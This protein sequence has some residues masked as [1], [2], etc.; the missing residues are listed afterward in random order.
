MRTLNHGLTALSLLITVSAC[1]RQVG[2]DYQ[3]ESLLR[4]E[5]SVTIPQEF[6]TTELVP[7][8]AFVARGHQ[9]IIDVGVTGQFPAN[10]TL[11]VFELPPAETIR[12]SYPGGPALAEGYVAAAPPDH[13]DAISRAVG[14]V[15]NPTSPDVL[16]LEL[17]TCLFTGACDANCVYSPEA[18]ACNPLCY[19]G[20]TWPPSDPAICHLQV[21]ECHYSDPN[22]D[23]CAFVSASGNPSVEIAGFSKNVRI[24][25]LP[26]AVPADSLLSFDYSMAG[27]PI[28]AGYHL[29]MENP[30]PPSTDPTCSGPVPWEMALDRYNAAHGT[31]LTLDDFSGPAINTP[32]SRELRRLQYIAAR[33]LGCLEAGFLEHTGPITIDLGARM[34][35]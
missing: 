33:E 5:G 32:E 18:E 10:F 35:Y 22:P 2:T 19:E 12:E 26:E 14:G 16:P 29:Q 4:I 1:E 17:R 30:T 8:I 13:P 3:G 6:A 27:A 28:S 23:A 15:G 24:L 25:Y 31:S 20:S 7:V 21:L 11:D 34:P 9:R